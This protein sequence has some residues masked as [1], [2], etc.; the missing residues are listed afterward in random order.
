MNP[1]KNYIIYQILILN[2]EYNIKSI[3]RASFEKA[4]ASAGIGRK[5]AMDR[6]GSI[7]D[8]FEASL[9]EAAYELR[10]QGFSEAEALKNKILQIRNI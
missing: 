5:M 6:F 4:A 2:V 3:D 8:R 7:A 9:N 1:L 10:S